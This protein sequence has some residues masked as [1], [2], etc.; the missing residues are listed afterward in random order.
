M[1]HGYMAARLLWVVGIVRPCVHPGRFWMA[2]KLEYF[3]NSL[4]HGLTLKHFFDGN[5]F[6]VLRFDTVQSS[7]YIPQ[8]FDVVHTAASI[9]SPTVQKS[10]SIP[11]AIAGVLRKVLWR[12]TKL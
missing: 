3:Y 9:K 2:A 4:P 5:T 8:F 7:D 11:A 1:Q 12:F 10:R 6:D